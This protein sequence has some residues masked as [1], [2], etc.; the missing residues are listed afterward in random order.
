MEQL[1]TAVMGM[2]MDQDLHH[3]WIK[4]QKDTNS[5]LSTSD[6]VDFLQEQRKILCTSSLHTSHRRPQDS[7]RSSSRSQPPQCPSS[8]THRHGRSAA[9]MPVNS[10]SSGCSFSDQGNHPPYLCSV[11]EGWSL[12][13]CK[14]AVKRQRLCFNCLSSGHCSNSCGSR[15][16]CRMCGQRHHSLLH[17]ESTQTTPSS[18]ATNSGEVSAMDAASPNNAD[19][20]VLHITKRR[21][22]P[23]MET[24]MAMLSANGRSTCAWLLFDSGAAI[25]VITSKTAQALQAR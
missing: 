21:Q 22:T 12:D 1:L 19:Q 24:A 17:S 4:A 3:E 14:N 20:T 23:L 6:L 15:R 18:T 5:I 11:F 2:A 25:S 7:I 9:V 10:S 16:N 8:P 13:C